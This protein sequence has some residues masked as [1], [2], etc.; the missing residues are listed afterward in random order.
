MKYN[1]GDKVVITNALKSLLPDNYN[2]RIVTVAE[3]M[4]DRIF[5]MDDGGG[6]AYLY[7]LNSCIRDTNPLER[8][9]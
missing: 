3:V 2:K 7:V 4:I 5:F 9:I 6:S 8:L 1:T